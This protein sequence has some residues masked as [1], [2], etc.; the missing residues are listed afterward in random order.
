MASTSSFDVVSRYDHQEVVNALDQTRREINTRFDLKDS[1]STVM[2]DGDRITIT[3][4]S[5]GRLST[6]RDLLE[7]KFVRRKV[8]LKTLR[9]SEPE[10]ASGG[11]IRQHAALIQG[12]EQDLGKQ[13]TKSVRQ[14]YPK[15]QAQLQGDS[16]RISAKSKD[17][18]QKVIRLLESKDYPVD[19]QFVNYR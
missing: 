8:S 12:I 15:V 17:D 6:V 16:I 13:I 2:L 14:E 5:K 18:L 7:S 4:D 19:L 11:N 1:K 9:Y 10:P 3:A